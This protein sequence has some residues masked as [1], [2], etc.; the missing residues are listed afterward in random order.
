MKKKILEI[1]MWGICIVALAVMST[2]VVREYQKSQNSLEIIQQQIET[3]A[4]HI[5]EVNKANNNLEKRITEFE[6]KQEEDK[7]RESIEKTTVEDQEQNESVDGQITQSGQS[8]ITDLEVGSI[9]DV[10]KI[11]WSNLDSYFQAYEIVEGDAVYNRIIGNHTEK[12]TI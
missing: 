2:V 6:K 3:I 5:E 11:S 1:F 9:V 4:A 12:I 10:S 8:G 7:N